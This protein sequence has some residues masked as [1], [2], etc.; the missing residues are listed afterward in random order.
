MAQWSYTGVLLALAAPALGQIP[1]QSGHHGPAMKV[2]SKLIL[3]FGAVPAATSAV[4][5]ELS[6]RA[7][8]IFAGHVISIA[9]ANG[10]LDIAFHVDESLRGARGTGT[11]V[12]REWAGLW[13]GHPDRYT[14]GQYWLM[15]LP[16]RGPSGMS[17]PVGGMAGAIPIIAAGTA[18][19]ADANGNLPPDESPDL[20]TSVVD[21]RWLAT[22]VERTP[23]PVRHLE[24]ESAPAQWSGPTPAL[25]SP[26][27]APASLG[28]VLALLRGTGGDS[29]GR[30]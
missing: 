16:A 10:F 3:P 14:P 17:S 13:M 21:L 27:A 20:N 5:M 29:S 9:R 1:S 2:T 12:L 18:P 25:A 26:S 6:S 15:L 28:A 8:I 22:H 4:L 7:A 11:Y 19:L 30:R 24:A 23:A